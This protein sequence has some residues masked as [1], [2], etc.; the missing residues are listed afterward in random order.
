MYVETGRQNS[1]F[2]IKWKS[3]RTITSYYILYKQYIKLHHFYSQQKS[4]FNI[5]QQLYLLFIR[6][7]KK[8]YFRKKCRSPLLTFNDSHA[9]GAQIFPK[10]RDELYFFFEK[11]ETTK[12]LQ[13]NAEMQTKKSSWGGW[14]IW[15]PRPPSWA[16]PW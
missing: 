13:T 8:K 10:G 5:N 2:N 4:L 1:S 7:Y 12:E 3:Y 6:I 11:T 9:V 15:Y 14:G 16:R